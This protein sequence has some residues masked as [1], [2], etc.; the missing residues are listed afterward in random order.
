MKKIHVRTYRTTGAG[1]INVTH[2]NKGET[3]DLSKLYEATPHDRRHTT[4]ETA[5]DVF[6]YDDNNLAWSMSPNGQ[7]V[8]SAQTLKLLLGLFVEDV[9]RDVGDPKA[10]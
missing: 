8:D 10:L 6:R 5:L 7:D 2:W 1:D 3:V 4:L 9:D